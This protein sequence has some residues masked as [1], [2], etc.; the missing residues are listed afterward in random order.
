ME[1]GKFGNWKIWKLE[2][3]EIGKLEIGKL[4]NWEIGKLENYLNYCKWRSF[5]NFHISK[6]SNFHI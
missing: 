1:I 5:S 6:F 4:G 3:L 2:N